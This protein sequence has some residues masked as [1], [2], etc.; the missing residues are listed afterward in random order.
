MVRKEQERKQDTC[1]FVHYR[2]GSLY[3]T[4]SSRRKEGVDEG[5]NKGLKRYELLRRMVGR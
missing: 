2:G 4:N 1:I 3:P 5:S